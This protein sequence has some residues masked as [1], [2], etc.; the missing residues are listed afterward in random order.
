MKEQVVKSLSR[1]TLEKVAKHLGENH[2]GTRKE[3]EVRIL[4]HMYAQI[5]NARV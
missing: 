2:V 4:K 1:A 5:N 3:V